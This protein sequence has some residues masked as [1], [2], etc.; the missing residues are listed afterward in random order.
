M[1]IDRPITL[2]LYE[3]RLKSVNTAAR[4]DDNLSTSFMVE[5]DVDGLYTD[6]RVKVVDPDG[7]AILHECMPTGTG[8]WD[9]AAELWWPVNE[10]AQVLYDVVVDLY[11]GVSPYIECIHF[12]YTSQDRLVD[13]HT[14]K[15]GFRSVELV[16]HA[17]E[18]QPGTS[19][20]FK[21]N[22]KPIFIGGS[23]WIPID[24][25]LATGTRDRYERWLDLMVL[26][27]LHSVKTS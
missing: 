22:G 23:N 16:Q 8:E 9:L 12:A 24:T 18:G 17:L 7:H 25:V 5:V 4:V 20:F 13:S 27:V 1:G 15:V 3:S 6:I 14:R 10:G 26:A 21:I 11:N 19:F 2:L